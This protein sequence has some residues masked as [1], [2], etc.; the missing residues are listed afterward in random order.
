M[1]VSVG[2]T[3][4]LVGVLDGVAVG[5]GVAVGVLVGVSSVGVL[6]GMACWSGWPSAVA[7]WS[8]VLVGVRCTGRRGSR[9]RCVSRSMAV[10]V[11]VL[12]GSRWPVCW[13]AWPSG[14]RVGGSRGRRRCLVGVLVGSGVSVGVLVGAGACVLVGRAVGVGVGMAYWLACSSAAVS[15]SA[16]WSAW[17]AG[18]GA[19][20]SG[21]S[22]GYGTWLVGVLVGTGVIGRRVRR[23]R[24]SRVRSVGV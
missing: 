6:V 15:R 24:C 10:A 4:V 3:G 11:G 8:V 21:V 12:V 14:R 22:V 7:C 1:G 16:C 13:S 19:V 18:R 23:Q 2:G 20:G 9:G 17:R 5:S